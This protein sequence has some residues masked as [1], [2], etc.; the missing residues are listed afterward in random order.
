MKLRILTWNVR[1]LNSREHRNRI[2][3]ALKKWNADIVVLQE[4]KIENMGREVI[5]DI[6]PGY[7]VDWVALDASGTAGG[8]IILWDRRVVSKINEFQKKNFYL[9]FFQEC[10]GW[11]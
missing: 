1:G 7:F 6:W 10:C 3:S 11:L 9:L 8:I 2:K 4:S 5:R